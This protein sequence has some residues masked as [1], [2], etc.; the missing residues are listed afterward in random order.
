[1]TRT[2]RFAAP[3][4]L[5][6][7]LAPVASGQLTPDPTPRYTLFS[8]LHPTPLQ[9]V[10]HNMQHPA[11]R[12]ALGDAPPTPMQ[13]V[14]G[15]SD[16]EFGRAWLGSLIGLGFAYVSD[17]LIHYQTD[18]SKADPFLSEDDGSGEV[19]YNI[20]LYGGFAPLFSLRGLRQVNPWYGNPTGGYLG[21][22]AGAL[23]GLALWTNEGKKESFRG[24]A[25]TS[26]L[27]ALGTTIGY[28]LFN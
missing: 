3:L 12:L 11:L 21:G 7:L 6:L 16:W 25:L 23:G 4:V 8:G 18:F 17:L 22:V 26:G 10:V 9:M 13:Y 24:I 5:I 2:L 20:L 1:V 27:M 19:V 15:R 14:Y 28:H